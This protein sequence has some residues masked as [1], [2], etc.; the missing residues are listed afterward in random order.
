MASFTYKALSG[1]G[2]VVTGTLDAGDR[3][4]ALRQLD[5]KGLQ[6]VTIS[7]SAGGAEPAAKPE[8]DAD[9]RMLEADLS[10]ATGMRVAIDHK[11]GG[12]SGKVSI[13][14]NSLAQL[15]DL[16]RVLS[17]ADID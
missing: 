10:A 17:A 7:Q 6:P 15:D 11:P 9:T 4:E 16:C 1:S 5:R 3:G 13:S 12:E 2:S 14:Y 8:K